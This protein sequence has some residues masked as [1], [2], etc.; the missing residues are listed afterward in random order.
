MGTWQF[1]LSLIATVFIL[2]LVLVF[3]T[4][5]G[6]LFAQQS[7]A[8]TP[9]GNA[10]QGNT[11]NPGYPVGAGNNSG[12]GQSTAPGTDPYSQPS[13]ASSQSNGVSPTNSQSGVAGV[14]TSA[15]PTPANEAATPVSTTYS[16]AGFPWGWSIL[17][18]IIGLIIGG[19]AFHRPAVNRDRDN[20]RR[21]A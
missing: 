10:N 13:G 17:S 21:V 9:Q 6:P 16:R 14:D 11:A 4:P 3:S 1:R 18:F 15:P 12:T 2:A 20:L 5:G 8:A 19:L 7:N